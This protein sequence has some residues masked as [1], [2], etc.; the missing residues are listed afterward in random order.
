MKRAGFTRTEFLLV[1]GI[2][3]L[4]IALLLPA[5]YRSREAARQSQCK[6][7]LKQWGLALHSYHDVHQ[8]FPPYAGGTQ[9]NGERLSGR[10]MLINYL[11]SNRIWHEIHSSPGQG[12]DPMT[13]RVPSLPSEMPM[14]IC[15]SS[16]VPP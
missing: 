1:V 11:D 4:L 7:N 16:D 3:T 10:V 13:L 14:M 5:V 8:M 15:P 2:L 9:E 6:N 12:G